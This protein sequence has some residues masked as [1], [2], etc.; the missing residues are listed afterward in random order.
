MCVC[1][2]VCVFPELIFT[3]CCMYALIGTC[4]YLPNAHAYTHHMHTHITCTSH[5]H[6]HHMHT[7]HMHTHIT[8]TS[9]A[10]T[11]HMHIT[12]THTSHAHTHHMHTHITCTHT[13]H[14]IIYVSTQR[15]IFTYIIHYQH[16]FYFSTA[17]HSMCAYKAR[18][19]CMVL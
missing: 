4:T 12:C 10:H 13:S 17:I 18:I 15:D 16:S 5:A 1:V 14:A 11:H 7:H 2:C 8:C 9:H 19:E 3:F 6:T